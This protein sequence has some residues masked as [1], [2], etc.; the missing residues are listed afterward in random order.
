MA[1][2]DSAQ[3]RWKIDSW[4]GYAPGDVAADGLELELKLK[5]LKACI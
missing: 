5:G 2:R 3:R 4:I 1:S